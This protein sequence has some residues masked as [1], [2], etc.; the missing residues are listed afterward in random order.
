MP[1]S[2]PSLGL[3]VFFLSFFSYFS[4]HTPLLKIPV[5]WR[6]AV[7][8]SL[9]WLVCFLSFFVLFFLFIRRFSCV[10]VLSSCRP[11][12]PPSL[13]LYKGQ[14]R[15]R[16]GDLPLAEREPA[17]DRF[18]RE[19]F[20]AIPMRWRAGRFMHSLWSGRERV[21]RPPFH[22]VCPSGKS[23]RNLGKS[24]NDRESWPSGMGQKKRDKPRATLISLRST[25]PP[26]TTRCT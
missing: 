2:H 23:N 14:S 8:P 7:L 24:C 19:R 25:S 15:F 3:S 18:E 9:P 1:S 21:F 22:R 4:Y 10:C 12:I 6:R 26:A 13:A 11:P 5:W 20:L 17:R 16:T